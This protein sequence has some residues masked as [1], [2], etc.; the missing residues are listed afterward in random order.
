M[1]GAKE[2]SSAGATSSSAPGISASPRRSPPRFRSRRGCPAPTRRWRRTR[3][4]VDGTLQAFFDTMVPGRVVAVTQSG[5]PIHPQAIAG[6]D[7]EPGAVEADTLL[8]AHDAKIGFDTLVPP[9]IADLEARSAAAGGQ[10]LDL[11]YDAREA[12]CLA[13]LDFANPDRQVWEAAA[14]VPF[15]AFCAA[16]TSRTRPAATAVGYQV[17]GHPGTA[18]QGYRDFSFRRKPQPRHHQEGLPPVMAEQIDVCIVGSGFGG[19][20]AAWRLAELYRAN[21]SDAS[22]R[23][24]RARPA[25]GAHGLPPVDGR[26]PPRRRLRP[27]PGP[28][29]ADRRR[30]PG[31]RRLQPLPRRLAAGAAG[32][33]RAPRPPSGR[34]ADAAD[35][36]RGDQP[37]PASIASTPGP[38]PRCASASRRGTRSRSR[39][40][41]GPRRCARPG[42]TCDRVPLAI[43]FERCVDAKWCYTGCV[44]GAK[45]SVITNYLRLGRA[46]RGGGAPAGPGRR[47]RARRA[48][49]PTAG[50]CAARSSTRSTKAP[51]GRRSRRSSARC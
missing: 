23:R 24:A 36:A 5:A 3:T 42:H 16:A 15:T 29:R 20:I 47:G 38:R 11:G 19:S 37:R 32:D 33:L 49:A 2:Q 25:Q 8:L 17:M 14:A 6:V 1:N 31:R 34:P 28:G 48:R 4:C 43:D 13:G 27:D 35:V 18:P 39:A 30:Q 40:G 44:F 50:W 22:V 51:V 46:G 10:F 26:R 7:P 21:D 41:S 12:V 9:F 45:N